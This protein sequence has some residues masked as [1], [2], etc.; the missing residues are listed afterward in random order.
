MSRTDPLWNSALDE[1]SHA[2]GNSKFSLFI[3]S[4]A[5]LQKKKGDLRVTSP[6]GDGFK[7]TGG[8]NWTGVH[9][10]HD[11]ASIRVKRGFAEALNGQKSKGEERC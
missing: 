9:T 11:Q 4:K 7:S 6:A 5:N 3:M 2:F 1:I 10:K 8:R